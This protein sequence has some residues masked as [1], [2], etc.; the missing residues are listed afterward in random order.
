[1]K[2]RARRPR[3]YVDAPGTA[4]DD[5]GHGW[6]TV[7]TPDAKLTVRRALSAQGHVR[8][9]RLEQLGERGWQVVSTRGAGGLTH[10]GRPGLWS[11]AAAACCEGLA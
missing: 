6:E 10:V 9:A 11:I 4:L 5:V 7:T 1:M 8:H 2:G 3:Q